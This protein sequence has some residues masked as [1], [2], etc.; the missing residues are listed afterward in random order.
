ME[1]KYTPK[2]SASPC[3]PEAERLHLAQLL[4]QEG[5]PCSYCI[6]VFLMLAGGE[7]LPR[8]DARAYGRHLLAAHG[9]EPYSIR[10]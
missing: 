1:A 5:Q 7:K 4:E 3:R 2:Y 10:P 8:R 9:L 6:A